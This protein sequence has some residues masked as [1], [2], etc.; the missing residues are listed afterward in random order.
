WLA[1]AAPAQVTR[2]RHKRRG[3]VFRMAT[4]IVTRNPGRVPNL[5]RRAR[6]GE[7]G[8]SPRESQCFEPAN[9]LAQAARAA[10]LPVD[11]AHAGLLGP[12]MVDDA[13]REIERRLAAGRRDLEDHVGADLRLHRADHQPAADADLAQLGV[14]QIEPRGDAEAAGD[15]DGDAGVLAAAGGRALAAQGFDH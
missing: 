8:P 15:P 11:E 13:P 14:D 10:A 3:S 7:A 5:P 1:R 6:P 9:Q 12:G 4:S 2:P